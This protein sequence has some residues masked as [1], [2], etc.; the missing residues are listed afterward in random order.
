LKVIES[1]IAGDPM[2]E[3][4]RWLKLTRAEVCEQMLLLGI[5]VSRNIARKLMKKHRLVKRKMQRKRS[6]GQST[7]R[8]EQFHNMTTEKEKFMKS[9]NPIISMDTKKKE[10]IG[11]NL[12]RNGSVYC[13]EAIEVSDHD[14][15]YLA[16]LKIAPH[17]IY[18]ILRAVTICGFC[19]VLFGSA[20]SLTLDNRITIALRVKDH[21]DPKRTAP[22]NRKL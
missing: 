1:P 2:N 4:I 10:L 13:T 5:K 19:L 14:Y 12:Y 16:D 18:D 6:I 15:T 17:G 9:K 8:E 3:K 7:D 21:A 20:W 11:G 22:K